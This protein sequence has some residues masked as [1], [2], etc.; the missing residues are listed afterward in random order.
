MKGKGK[1]T[2][3]EIEQICDLIRQKLIADTNTQK[4]IRDQ[5]RK[6]G[7]YATDF[8]IGGGYTVDDFLEAIGEKQ[9][10]GGNAML[11]STNKCN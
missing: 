4:K 2:A 8:G 10:K 1:F 7:F 6:L 11:R 3:E 5:I 9:K